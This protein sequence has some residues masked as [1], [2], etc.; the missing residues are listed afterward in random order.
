LGGL[1]KGDGTGTKSDSKLKTPETVQP[2]TDPSN[3]L[4]NKL[5]KGKTLDDRTLRQPDENPELRPDDTVL[6]DLTPI[7][8][9]RDKSSN[10]PNGPNAGGIDGANGLGINGIPGLNG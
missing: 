10:Y 4:L 8:R 7:D 2:K 3:E 6:I 5:K 1:G 9:Y